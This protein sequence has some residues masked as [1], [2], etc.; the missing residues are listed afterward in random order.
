MCRA[1]RAASSCS[2]LTRPAL[3]L[4]RTGIAPEVTILFPPLEDVDPVAL[5]A[6]EQLY[7][8]LDNPPVKTYWFEQENN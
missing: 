2:T 5:V 4:T 6:A 1:A 7:L 8:E 3:T